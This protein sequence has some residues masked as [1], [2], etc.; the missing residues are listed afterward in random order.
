M[1]VQMRYTGFQVS[2][3]FLVLAIL[4]SCAKE[5]PQKI[6]WVSSLDEAFK[7]ASEK[8]QPIVAEFWSA[9]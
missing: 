4:A 1:E 9:G 8:N 3:V 5:V 2:F 6:T 7:V